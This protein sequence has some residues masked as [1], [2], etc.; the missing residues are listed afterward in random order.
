MPKSSNNAVIEA[1]AL[2]TIHEELRCFNP[3]IILLG[4][5]FVLEFGSIQ[6]LYEMP[7]I[8][9]LPLITSVLSIS[10]VG[11]YLIKGRIE[12]KRDTVIF[13][14]AFC[15][16]MIIYIF[17]TTI[18]FR[19]RE[20]GI[21]LYLMYMIYYLLMISSINNINELILTLDIW[22]ASMAYTCLHG[23]LQG[24]LLWGSQW[25]SDENIFSIMCA[26]GISF[27]YFLFLSYKSWRKKICYAICLVLY[28]GGIIT[29][30]SRGGL[31]TL[32]IVGSMCWLF[33]KNKLRSLVLIF[34]LISTVI[35]FM[36]N[37][38]LTELQHVDKDVQ[39]G[40]A[41]ERVYLWRLAVDMFNDNKI[42][43]VGPFNFGEYFPNYD[44]RA[45]N[46]DTMG[47]INWRGQ[48]WVAH[49]TPIT[50]LAETGIIGIT[51]LSFLQFCLLKNWRRANQKLGYEYDGEIEKRNSGVLNIL[52]NAGLISQMGF[53]VGSLFLTLTSYPFYYCIVWFSDIVIKLMLE[54]NKS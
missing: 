37:N 54:Y 8:L 32:F 10:F 30:A 22:L 33:S 47:G 14:C 31:V 19:A 49:S 23:I 12:L 29:A 7:N 21:K 38:F 45:E 35:T 26:I 1:L 34:L 27:S 17:L 18:D 44:E 9:R 15:I 46:R 2:P 13:F 20:N 11:Y 41:G 50:F 53:W 52:N 24:G 43:G 51:L 4:L 3:G 25:V 48:K 42:V 36:P 39:Q 40:Q 16:F 6:G 28:F 5:Y